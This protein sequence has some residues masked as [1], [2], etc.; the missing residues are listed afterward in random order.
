MEKLNNPFVVYGYKG[1][2]Y[3]CDRKNE[4]SKIVSAL[5][6][7]RNVTLIAPRRMGKTG[8]IHHVFETMKNE[9][10]G[11]K[12]FYIDIFATKDLSQMVQMMAQTIIGA[13]DTPSQN[14]MRKIQTFFASWRPTLSLDPSTGMP[15]VSLDIVPSESKETLKSLFE[16]I[17]ASGQ[18]C[19]IAIDEFQQ[20]TQY[21]EKEVEALLRSYIQFLP[22][23]CFIFSGS[24]QHLMAEMF[25]SAKRPFFQSTQ[26]ISLE[27][28]DKS[29]YLAFANGFFAS[30][31]RMVAEEDFLYIF[32]K[33]KG[34]TWYIQ[35]VLNRIYEIKDSDI[36]TTLIERCMDNLID[37]Q[38]GVYQNY[39]S[40]LTSNQLS[41]LVAIAKEEKAEKVLSSNFIRKHKLPSTSSVKTAITSLL[42]KQLICLDAGKY[43]IN[44]IFFGFWLKKKM[45]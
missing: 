41:L 30:Q 17:K 8:L 35:S 16:Y 26:I 40:W 36:T 4:T 27:S 24:V 37:E 34:I 1:T 39:C 20:I 3:F 6:N 7:E 33:V 12:C 32:K 38:E 42:D 22:N 45:W 19:Y 18:K 13:L 2:E 11:I 31:N 23:V 44:D 43:S 29:E 10:N 25:L 5:Y 14:A 9:D 21:P 28:I 15:T